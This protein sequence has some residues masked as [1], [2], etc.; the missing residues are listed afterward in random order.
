MSS[1][2]SSIVRCPG[3]QS[4]MAV[5]PAEI[6][7]PIQCRNCG[8]TFTAPQAARQSAAPQAPRHPAEDDE[9]WDFSSAMAS[10]VQGAQRGAQTTPP[11]STAWDRPSSG[12]REAPDAGRGYT[13]DQ[14][15]DPEPSD[16]HREAQP[17]GGYRQ[18]RTGSQDRNRSTLKLSHDI[19]AILR[20]S[21]KAAG[22]TNA[23][24]GG[25]GGF[26]VGL[27]LGILG[28]KSSLGKVFDL[29]QITTVIPI[30]ILCL[31]GWG[32]MICI[33]RMRKLKALESVMQPE[34]MEALVGSLSA[35]GV[36]SQAQALGNYPICDYHPFYRQTRAVLD[37]WLQR[38]SLQNADLILQK[39]ETIDSD[40]VQSGYGLVRTFVWAMPVLGL[41]GTVIGISIAVGGFAT[42]L[43]GSGSNDV[44]VIKTSLVSV[45]SGLSFAF[46]ITLEGLLGALLIML[47]STSLQ[48]REQ[49][50]LSRIQ[51][52]MADDYLPMLMKVMPEEDS[53]EG[54]DRLI[55]ESMPGGELMQIWRDAMARVSNETMKAIRASADEMITD[56]K[57]YRETN[58]RE[59]DTVVAK[60]SESIDSISRQSSKTT[61]DFIARVRHLARDDAGRPEGVPNR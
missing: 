27:A 28:G 43:N 25:I 53:N 23:L 39:H 33:Y 40:A 61:D 3:C 46:L 34:Q 60:I 7:N 14:R 29:H 2:A 42:F 56:L 36:E 35:D 18:A 12:N 49:D 45:T 50:A 59:V 26:V 4:V 19:P 5:D 16:R 22:V 52:F 30:G 47:P 20:Q 58:R 11:S 24:I 15:Q 44:N 41:I 17:S 21:E 48:S 55:D 51:S 10:D 57:T 32:V 13:S 8:L 9:H 6:N 37:Q 1:P 54:K 31:F 38:A